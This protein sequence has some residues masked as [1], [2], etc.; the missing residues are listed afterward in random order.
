MRLNLFGRALG[1]LL[2]GLLCGHTWAATYQSLGTW[3]GPQI[4]PFSR[5]GKTGIAAAKRRARKYRN[6]RRQH[7]GRA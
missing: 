6:R 7:H 2:A 3:G 1:A 5:R 4:I